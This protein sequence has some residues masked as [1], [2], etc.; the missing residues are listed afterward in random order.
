MSEHPLLEPPAEG[1]HIE[2]SDVRKVRPRD[3][4]VRF[5]FGAFTSAI[6]GI[7]GLAFGARAGGL[8]LAF[9]A[10][11][12]ATVTLIEDEEGTQAAREDA[13]GA[14]IGAIALAGFAVVGA[15]LFARVPAAPVLV[16][17][18]LAWAAIA[19]GGY[20]LICRRGR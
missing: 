11:L 4:L 10:I 6:A 1:V 19:I 7:V 2:P 20:H 5:A 15:T 18:T 14:I 13:R 9:P 12:L 8:F 17:A 16:L 3:L